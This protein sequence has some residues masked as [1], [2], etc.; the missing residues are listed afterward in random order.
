MEDEIKE[1]LLKRAKGYYSRESTREFSFDGKKGVETLV[2]RKVSTKYT[3]PDV[4]AAKVLLALEGGGIED[5]SDV[6]LQE[7]RERILR[8]INGADKYQKGVINETENAK[9]GQA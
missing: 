9:S 1:A 2:K 4:A 8:E 6:E 3:P 7:E 5:M